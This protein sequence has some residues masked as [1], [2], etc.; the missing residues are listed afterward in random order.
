[1]NASKGLDAHFRFSK[2]SL[3]D[4]VDCPRRF[5]LR[6]VQGVRWPSVQAEP[7]LAQEVLMQRGDSFHRMLHQH[8]L[9]VPTSMIEAVA[10]NDLELLRW[11]RGFLAHVENDLAGRSH[12]EVTLHTRLGDHSL[13]AV[14]DLVVMND[15]QRVVIYDWKTS[16]RVPRREWLQSRLQTRLYPYVM[17]RAGAALFGLQ[18]LEAAQV[19]M[20]YWFASKPDVIEVFPYS[21]AQMAADEAYL[22]QLMDTMS[23]ASE[24]PLTDDT[25]RCRFCLYRSLCTRGVGAGD[26]GAEGMLLDE[27]TAPP[28]FELDFD[29][30]AEVAF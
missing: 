26:L 27:E 24:F 15:S 21:A 29:Q 7:L 17:V 1:M 25:Q 5:E 8:A 16:L 30:V 19:E 9:G 28:D 11:W 4:Y 2:S 6:Y 3:Q 23:T 12:A 14:Y 10:A 18:V 22:R 13:A 20:R